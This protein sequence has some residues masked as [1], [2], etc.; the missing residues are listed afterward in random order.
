MLFR[1][2]KMHVETGT[3]REGRETDNQIRIRE[4][5]RQNMGKEETK[6]K[7]VGREERIS[8]KLARYHT[9]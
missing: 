7:R 2:L 4:Q 3:E 1:V 9:S 6:V 5:R 8:C